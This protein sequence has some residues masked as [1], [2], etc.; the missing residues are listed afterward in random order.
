MTRTLA[1]CLATLLAACGT[2]VDEDAA[3]GQALRSLSGPDEFEPRFIALLRAEAPAL[4]IA[5]ID[6]EVN[7]TLLLERQDGDF[8]YWLS[9]DGA[10]LILQRGVLH[11][12]RGLGEGLLASDLSEPLALLQALQSG[13]SDRFHTYLD[14]NDVAITRTYRCRIDNEGPADITINGEARSTRRMRENCRSLNQEFTNLYW[15]DPTTR[16]ILLSRQWA[17][18]TLGP[19]STRIV[20]R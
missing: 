4:Q 20:P 16:T 17:G 11:G 6:Q 1:L 7:G 5:I 2:V 3:I 10:Q 12:T 18:P 13:W 15:V 19:I 9:P 8:A 14:G